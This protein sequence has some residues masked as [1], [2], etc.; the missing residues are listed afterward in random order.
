MEESLQR[1]NAAQRVQLWAERI[2]ECRSSG[3][4]VRAW[5]KEHEI[6]EKT[7]YYWQRRLYQQMVSTAEAVNFAEI[8]C[9]VQTRQDSGVAARIS[10][11][12]AIVEVYPEADT[13][14]IQTIL[15][16]LKSC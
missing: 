15:Q 1:L 14:M 3:M 6:S 2:A 5:C 10:L 4:S 8:S 13:Q 12:G 16:T 7:Y 9:S 11:S